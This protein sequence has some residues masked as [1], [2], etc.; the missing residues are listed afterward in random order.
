M[1]SPHFKSGHSPPGR[2]SDDAASASAEK[3]D[4]VKYYDDVYFSSGSSD[5][6]G[7]GEVREAA[8]ATPPGKVKGLPG[9]FILK[10]LVFLSLISSETSCADSVKRRLAL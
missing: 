5:E 4:D 2:Q 1:A 10:R 6:G 8:S 7:G 3:P 9:C